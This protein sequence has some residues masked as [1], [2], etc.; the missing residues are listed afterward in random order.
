MSFFALIK[1]ATIEYQL[2]FYYRNS[3]MI[4]SHVVSDLHDFLLL[5]N[6]KEEIFQVALFSFVSKTNP[7]AL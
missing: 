6:M 3:F 5:W 2:H 7:K 1:Q 4:F